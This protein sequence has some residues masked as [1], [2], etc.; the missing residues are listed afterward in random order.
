MVKAAV[1]T[2]SQ[3]LKVHHQLSF[4]QYRDL[5]LVF[6]QR[7]RKQRRQAAAGAGKPGGGRGS[8]QGGKMPD[9]AA[10][11]DLKAAGLE[12]GSDHKDL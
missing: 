12:E 10:V 3:H 4:N 2:I 11:N 7:Q 8:K 6:T 1:S 9:P 5:F